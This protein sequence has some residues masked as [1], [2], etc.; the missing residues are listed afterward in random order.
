MNRII[1]IGVATFAALTFYYCFTIGYNWTSNWK[2]KI[3][4]YIEEGDIRMGT[5]EN[6]LLSNYIVTTNMSMDQFSYNLFAPKINDEY[7]AA[8][9]LKVVVVESSYYPTSELCVIRF[10]AKR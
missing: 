8:N 1:K 4:F 10:K 9:G 3:Q 6:Q 5:I 7:I 2:W